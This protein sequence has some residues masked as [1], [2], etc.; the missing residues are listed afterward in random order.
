MNPVQRRTH[1]TEAG[2]FK[3]S[4]AP[5]GAEP[6]PKPPSLGLASLPGP[7]WI[8]RSATPSNRRPRRLPATAVSAMSPIPVATRRA[9]WNSGTG[10]ARRARLH[11]RRQFEQPTGLGLLL[12]DPGEPQAMPR[13]RVIARGDGNARARSTRATA[14]AT[15]RLVQETKIAST[16][17][18][19]AIFSAAASI[20]ATEMRAASRSSCAVEGGDR[21]DIDAAAVEISDEV[22]VDLARIGRQQADAPGAQARGTR[23]APP[24]PASCRRRRGGPCE[25]RRKPPPR[26]ASSSPKC[27]RSRRRRASGSAGSGRGAGRCAARSRARFRGV[28]SL[29]LK[30][31]NS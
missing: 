8:R 23:R 11:R 5:R 3:S 6:G 18:A 25:F 20:E 22:G 14:S 10:R 27:S 16:P 17:G 1:S 21:G 28:I 2:S 7:F 29:S 26:P 12:L 24:S 9:A 30:T 19:A 13:H 4:I 31:R 15:R